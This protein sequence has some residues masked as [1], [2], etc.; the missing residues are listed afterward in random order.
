MRYLTSEGKHKLQM[1]E[2]KS[3]IFGFKKYVISEQLD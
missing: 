2:N 1:I 3:K